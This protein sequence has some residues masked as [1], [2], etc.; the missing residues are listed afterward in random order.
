M[1]RPLRITP[2]F[3]RR[4]PLPDP[5]DAE[6]KEERGRVLVVGGS[7]TVPGATLLAGVAALRAGAGKLQIATAKTAAIHLGLLVPEAKVMGL[8]VDG[9]GELS[10]SARE[11]EQAAQKADAMVVGAGMVSTRATLALTRTL[12]RKA[13]GVVVV[14]A[15]ALPA[16]RSDPLSEQLPIL[17]PHA[18]EMA[19]ML[20]IDIDE[21]EASPETTAH[22]AA[23][24]A[25]A[26]VAL[27]GAT[28]YIA[29]PDGRLWVHKGGGPGLGTSGSGDVLAGII[30]GLAARGA[31]PEQATVWAVFL[32][33]RAGAALARRQGTVGFLASEISAQIPKLL[34]RYRRS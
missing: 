28:T 21:V 6:G 10:K 32:H 25:H 3:L 29:H 17:T 15:G 14:D 5:H 33:A 27:K 1:K 7:G 26:V 20:D 19:D 22:E 13:T 31:A 4:W 12:L 24:N 11:V 34:D 23:R 2:A 30:G 9:D 18:G 16:F 8:P